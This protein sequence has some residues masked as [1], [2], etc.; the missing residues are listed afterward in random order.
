MTR[1]R[2]AVPILDAA[3]LVD[4][5]RFIDRGRKAQLAVDAILEARQVKDPHDKRTLELP[6]HQ[7]PRELERAAA[8]I[9][10]LERM[11]YTYHGAEL[12]KP[13]LGRRPPGRKA[14]PK[15]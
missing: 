2:Q 12:W 13:P 7:A 4:V 5:A 15:R 3:S 10:T 6:G 9:A 1:R 11:G 8:A 14:K